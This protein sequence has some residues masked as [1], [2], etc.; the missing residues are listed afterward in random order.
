[1]PRPWSA[2][3]KSGVN[4]VSAAARGP[5]ALTQVSEPREFTCEAGRVVSRGGGT[6]VR[7]AQPAG[8]PLGRNRPRARQVLCPSPRSDN[9]VKNHYHSKLRRALRK[10]NRLL[11]DWLRPEF[12]PLKNNIVAKIIQ[13]AEDYH[14]QPDP[15]QPSPAKTCYGTP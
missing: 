9:A 2:N 8:Q 7:A 12:K 13:T 10:L 15:T 6:A 3:L 1:M 5:F 4:L 11:H 14:S